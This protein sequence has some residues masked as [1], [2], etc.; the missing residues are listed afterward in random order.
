MNVRR[1]RAAAGG[2]ARF[3]HTVTIGLLVRLSRR[4]YLA[5]PS[6]IG[7][8]GAVRPGTT[9]VLALI[10]LA[11]FAAAVLQFVILGGRH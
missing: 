10:L 1:P 6:P 3:A 7:E 4:G 2:E 9:I 11:I 8:A 5:V